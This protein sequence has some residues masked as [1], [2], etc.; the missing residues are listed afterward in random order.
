MSDYAEQKKR[1]DAWLIEETKHAEKIRARIDELMKDCTTQNTWERHEA[2]HRAWQQ[3]LEELG[4]GL[5]Q[6][7]Y[8]TAPQGPLIRR[9]PAMAN[10]NREIGELGSDPLMGEYY[11]KDGYPKER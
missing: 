5:P 1:W 4:E 6:P 7:P 2:R 9:D 10:L 11:D 8:P 3:A